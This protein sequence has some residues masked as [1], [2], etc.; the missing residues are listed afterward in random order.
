M[1]FAERVH[2]VERAL[3]VYHKAHG[4]F[5]ENIGQLTEEG[6]NAE[7]A[8]RGAPFEYT[9]PVKDLGV[10]QVILRGRFRGHDFEVH[11]QNGFS[12]K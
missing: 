11:S 12:M 3:T 7:D 2:M 6:F 9:R 5:P 4:K 8:L 1:A 10:D